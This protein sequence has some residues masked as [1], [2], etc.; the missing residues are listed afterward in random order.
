MGPRIL[1]VDDHQI[2]RRGVP[3]LLADM[4]PEWEVCGEAGDAEEALKAIQTLEPDLTVV[5]ITM[6]GASGLEL[7]SRVRDLHLS[8]KMVLF[9]MHRSERLDIDVRAAGAQGYVLKS[10]AANDL[11]DAIEPILARGTF[12]GSA[13]AGNEEPDGKPNPTRNIAF[14]LCFSFC[15]L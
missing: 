10:Q 12:Y 4:R 6:P 9:T 11:V 3:T 7:A 13:A 5:D 8:S 2:V 15:A 1:I 14:L